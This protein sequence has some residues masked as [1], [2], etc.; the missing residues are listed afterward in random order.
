MWFSKEKETPLFVKLIVPTMAPKSLSTKLFGAS[1]MSGVLLT[2][3]PKIVLIYVLAAYFVN[4]KSASFEI[5]V[6]P[7]WPPVLPDSKVK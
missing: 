1:V 2:F 6:S 4:P 3:D 5:P 7:I